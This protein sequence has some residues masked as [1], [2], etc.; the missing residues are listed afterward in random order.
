MELNFID[1]GIGF[2]FIIVGLIFLLSNIYVIKQL[3]TILRKKNH[4]PHIFKP[5]K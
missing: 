4:L 3:V 1:I 2:I 5:V